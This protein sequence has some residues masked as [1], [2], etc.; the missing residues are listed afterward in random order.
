M[1]LSS[2][3]ISMTLV[4][5]FSGANA[6]PVTH[7]QA[8][9]EYLATVGIEEEIATL[10]DA[11]ISNLKS[12]TTQLLGSKRVANNEKASDLTK[13]FGDIAISVASEVYD[14]TKVQ[15]LYIQA[16]KDTYT[17]EELININELFRT[18]YGKLFVSKLVPYAQ[19]NKRIGEVMAQQFQSKIAPLEAKYNQQIAALEEKSNQERTPPPCQTQKIGDKEASICRYYKPFSPI[20][21]KLTYGGQTMFVLDS[22]LAQD[23][24]LSLRSGNK[25][26]EKL[27]GG[28]ID[29]VIERDTFPFHVSD[30]TTCNF[31]YDGEP[32]IQNVQFE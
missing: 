9:K 4:C 13:E 32:I 29:K 2:I 7:E 26:Q 30:G 23:V 22:D 25:R 10:K 18:D 3:V 17:H 11:V 1:K 19:R 6:D 16:L 27:I 14:W 8:A 24:V 12:Y 15:R 20:T 21:Y 5:C 28:C 31:S